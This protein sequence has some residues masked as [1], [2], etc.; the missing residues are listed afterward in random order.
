[1]D[2]W[3][4]L[5]RRRRRMMYMVPAFAIGMA[6]VSVL[7][8][9][10]LTESALSVVVTVV[11]AGM[12]IA[13]LSYGLRTLPCPNCGRPYGVRYLYRHGPWAP[14]CKVCRIPFGAELPEDAKTPYRSV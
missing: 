2:P 5:R 11:L 12:C 3:R 1:M 7:R 13:V 14:Y 6:S 4:E 8:G 10:G 9:L